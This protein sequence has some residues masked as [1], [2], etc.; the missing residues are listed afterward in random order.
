MLAIRLWLLKQC[1]LHNIPDT[2]KQE[3]KII[4][5]KRDV[6]MACQ[7]Y[8]KQ[9]SDGKQWRSQAGACALATRGCAPNYR[10]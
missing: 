5:M 4:K 7:K 3:R 10:H 1:Y 9:G 2:Q 6:G 8:I